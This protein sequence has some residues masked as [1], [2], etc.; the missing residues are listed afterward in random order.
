MSDQ[1]EHSSHE[2]PRPVAATLRML[3]R[4]SLSAN[5]FAAFCQDC[6]PDAFRLQRA[7]MDRAAQ[8]VILFQHAR[9]LDIWQKLRASSVL[10][11]R[12]VPHL[13]GLRF[14]GHRDILCGR[15]LRRKRLP[16]QHMDRQTWLVE[17]LA[18]GQR[19]ALK[20]L[21]PHSLENEL[22]A[23][24]LKTAV[25]VTE[26]LQSRHILPISDHGLDP[27][28]GPWI[29][30]EYLDGQDLADFLKA[31]PNLIL[32]NRRQIILQI[33]S[34]LC[35]MHRK[36]WVHRNLKPENVFV[37][38][39]DS[40]MGPLLNVRLSDFGLSR[41]VSEAHS[42]GLGR[43]GSLN[44]LAPEQHHAGGRVDPRMDV[45]TMGLLAYFILCD[46]WYGA[47]RLV[48]LASASAGQGRDPNARHGATTGHRESTSQPRASEQA[49]AQGI[50][51][52]KRFPIGFDEWFAKCVAVDAAQRYADA[53]KA[54]DA[55]IRDVLWTKAASPPRVSAPPPVV[56]PPVAPPQPMSLP[57]T[58]QR[59]GL[60]QIPSGS[61][62]MGRAADSNSDARNEPRRRVHLSGRFWVSATTVTREQYYKVT[63]LQ[64]NVDDGNDSQDLPVTKIEWR[65]ALVYCNQLSVYEGLEQVYNLSEPIPLWKTNLRRPGYRVLTEAE[66]EYVA[67]AGQPDFDGRP[68][69][70]LDACWCRENAGDRL[71]PVGR[72]KANA[73]G[74]FDALGNCWE[75]VW[76]VYRDDAGQAEVTDP[77]G[78]QA[79]A[80]NNPR[81][82]RG[83]CFLDLCS[84]LSPSRRQGRGERSRLIGFRIARSIP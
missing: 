3:L 60:I 71:H 40:P 24:E 11:E 38:Q 61:F 68:A 22:L 74:L 48:P 28:L 77:R 36:G 2:S 84:V 50:D 58:P 31:Q 13:S 75:W 59:P 80:G 69:A 56:P 78:P 51:P 49:R 70:V 54:R 17:D 47:P 72:K 46:T 4:D 37:T 35:D 65:Q 12:A 29:L 8:E 32:E 9:P 1:R 39:Q 41:Q 66:W 18:S 25:V 63:G 16:S 27:L 57:S 7:D 62:W 83:G 21:Q 19:Y 5:E 14:E 73:W 81:T 76:D 10:F 15:F 53:E 34:G 44:W 67:R 55:F 79:E 45:W 52:A 64:P 33:L 6:F 42:G 82:I 43:Y 26:K 20:H 30:T 23:G